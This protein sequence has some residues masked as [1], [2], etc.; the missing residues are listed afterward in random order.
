MVALQLRSDPA[1]AETAN[2]FVGVMTNCPAI[3]GASKAAASVYSGIGNYRRMKLAKRLG[4]C[5]S[6][7]CL[8]GPVV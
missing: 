6:F 7:N 1:R 3:V 8:C 2:K 5:A 4:I